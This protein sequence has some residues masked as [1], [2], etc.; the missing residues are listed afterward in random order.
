MKNILLI[1][2]ILFVGIIATSCAKR[3][4]YNP[5]GLSTE[6]Q[7]KNEDNIDNCTN[8]DYESD[9]ELYAELSKSAGPRPRGA[10]ALFSGIAKGLE[11]GARSNSRACKQRM[12]QK[13]IE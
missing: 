11:Y 2:L 3:E 6:T 5:N 9:A 4:S 13:E 7:S 1:P 10:A 12:F 8:H